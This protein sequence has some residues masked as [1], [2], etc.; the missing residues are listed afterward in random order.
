M[1]IHP[2]PAPYYLGNLLYDWQPDRAAALWEKSAQLGADFPVVYGNLAMVHA[3]PGP[4]E[5]REKS[6]SALERAVQFGGNA[7]VLNE[8]D[9][10]NEEDGV[11][12]EKRLAILQE[13]QAAVD[14][15]DVIARE[16]N[17]EIFSGN[18]EHA[19]ALIH[20][21]FFRAWE[22]GGRFDLGDA[23]VNAN[24]LRG[25]QH[26]AAGQYSQAL[27]D[28]QAASQLPTNLQGAAG[29]ISGRGN[30]I[31][32]RIGNA[33]EGLGEKENVRKAWQL[34]S[35]EPVSAPAT[36]P[37]RPNR[38]AG[39]SIGGI[40][41]GA[42]VV[43]TATYYRAVALQKLGQAEPAKA[44]FQQLA[45]SAAKI[46]GETPPP[47]HLRLAD[48]HYVSGL[49]KLGLGAKADAVQQL[50]AALRAA[51]DHVSA[52]LMLAEVGR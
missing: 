12:P 4:A 7:T 18:A 22:G 33:Y 32:Y 37:A 45:D 36:F 16:I 5:S 17:L 9:K 20:A 44:L 38:G 41:T 3:R 29:D 11:A 10:L 28:Y 25:N 50:E 31:N 52:K 30:E 6:R 42:H 21:R 19:I 39:R 26:F 35:V 8:L 49:G 51:P 46:L 23:W 40:G 24:L 15:D 14:R 2:I 47:E 13:H 27:A 1:P 48:A 34:A 43:E